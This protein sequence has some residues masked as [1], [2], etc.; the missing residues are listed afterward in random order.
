MSTEADDGRPSPDDLLARVAEERRRARRGRLT[1]FLGAAPGV[2]KTCA[3][4]ELAH[5]RRAAH[6]D[7]WIGWVET[8]R[9]PGTVSRLGT[10]PVLAPRRVEHRGAVLE[11]LDLDGALAQRPG[12]LLVDELAPTNAP[13][14]RHPKRWQDVDE[15]LDAGI[16][17]VTTLN[18]QHL[19]SV[20]D[21]V[22]RITGVAVRETVPDRLLDEADAVELVDLT[23]DALLAR[24]RAGDVYDGDR[25]ARALDGFFTPTTLVAL[26]E[27]AL[28]RVAERVD[29]DVDAAER[30]AGRPVPWSTSERLMV[31]VGPGPHALELVRATYRMASRLHAPWTAV[32]VEPA[33]RPTSAEARG[34]VA[35][36]LG[37]AER[38]GGETLVVRADRIGDE[39]VR[40][41]R[42]RSV[43]RLVVGKPTH[44]AWR[45]R[46][47]GS[48]VDAIVRQAVGIDVLITSVAPE[49]EA[50][51]A[52]PGGGARERAASATWREY[53]LALLPVLAV[54]LVGHA[55]RDVLTVVDQV[56]LLLL[57]V[58]VSALWVSGVPA[59]LAALVA[60]AAFDFLFVEPYYT[61]QVSD[62]GV[63]SSFVVMAAVGLVVSR[64]AGRVRESAEAAR[65]GER[66]VTA[67]HA[68]SHALAGAADADAIGRS[69]VHH[70]RE[71]LDREVA[72]WLYDGVALRAV[73]APSAGWLGEGDVAVARWV[74]EHARPA[75]R[76]TDTLGGS[77]G[78]YVPVPG[79]AGCVGVIGV[80][81]RTR[82]LHADQLQGVA[83]FAT[84]A[85]LAI[86]RV[87]LVGQAE[88][89]RVLVE[90][91][92]TR[93]DLLAAVSHDLRTPLA[94]IV[95][96]TGEVLSRTLDP[97]TREL[98]GD[99]RD[100]A[101]RLRGLVTGLLDLTRLSAG[102]VTPVRAWWSVTELAEAVASRCRP[103]LGARRVRVDAA[104][105]AT[106]LHV[107]GVLVGQLLEN[108]VR[109]AVEHA[110]A[111]TTVDVVT[112]RV[113]DATVTLV[114]RDDGPGIDAATAARMFERFYRAGDGARSG[115][116]GLGL[117]ICAAV[118]R[119]HGGTIHASAGPGGV[120]TEVRVTL[121]TPRQPEDGA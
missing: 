106:L 101:E 5:E 41:A 52:G 50:A 63:L 66:R 54:A 26:R 37:L 74:A 59:A 51:A 99:V 32:A 80:D 62:P 53:P 27:L 81:A 92:R 8:H 19:E 91:E 12:L 73:H 67:Q 86:D 6:V 45:D 95:G 119:V 44:P 115:G 30:A 42:R 7:V 94:T 40:L 105:D 108:L 31:A 79:R 24:I 102:G 69:V 97:V 85:G 117:A 57:S 46:L 76:G 78:V 107:D 121:P 39:L 29:R 90:T 55:L 3:M 103:Q 113:D 89:S 98:V 72:V 111:G 35:E 28:R 34:R 84:Q 25:A 16:D 75:G 47:R 10:L 68:L 110:P 33:S 36:A 109:N 61:L 43:T 64:L 14:G 83:Q 49:R 2:G 4:L 82:P 38:L 71:L 118:A 120:G 11:E 21:V 58:F 116:A 60:V 13:G 48:L 77:L 17:V 96:A 65:A 114:V 23:P 88:S 1:V 18:V 112:R 87:R 20:V 56:M 22:H 104:V 100:E 93:T 70:T 9:R 15:L